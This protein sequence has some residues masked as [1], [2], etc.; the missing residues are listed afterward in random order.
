MSRFFTCLT[1]G[2]L[3]LS[4]CYASHD[5][6]GGTCGRVTCTDSE[7]C[8]QVDC[9]GA[10]ACQ[11]ADLPC[12]DLFC[13]DTCTS[14]ADCT[15]AEVCITPEGAC[16]GSG[17]CVL[18]DDECSRDCPVVC[19]CDG[20]D[21]CNECIANRA[22]VSI[23][24]RGS[25][26]GELCGG[27][28]C[29]AGQQCCDDCAGGQRCVSAGLMCPV[30]PGGCESNFDCPPTEYCRFADGVCGPGPSG[31]TCEVRPTICDDFCTGVCGCDGTP[32]CNACF[33]ANLGVNVGP[34][35]EC[36][37]LPCGR[38]GLPCGPGEY[39]NL[40]PMC[41]GSDAQRCDPLPEACPDI[42]DPVCG[43]DGRTYDNGCIANAAR[44]TVASRG[45][46][47][48]PVAVTCAELL[49]MNPGLVSGTYELVDPSGV[50]QQ[51]YCDMFTDGGGWTLV[52]SSRGQT[53][54]DRASGHHPDLAQYEPSGPNTGVWDGLRGIAPTTDVRFTCRPSFAMGNAVDLSFYDV[55]WYDEW[56]TGTDAQSCFSED[57]GSGRDLPEP[58]RRNNLTGETLMV[59]TP[60][61]AGYLEGED[62]CG[63]PNDFT[64][65]FRDRGMDSNEM[66][67]TDW[68]E[69][70][71]TPKC[72][73]MSLMDGVWQIWIRE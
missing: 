46:C 17:T 32:Y 22:G 47:A 36:M 31:G 68:G 7:V 44:V 18:P 63:D 6:T 37:E 56:T 13:G 11:T 19:G 61:D 20:S 58:A 57:N 5:G 73:F 39:C 43:C 26:S 16:G 25:C 2:A 55:I 41:G 53:I 14:D 8:C 27:V 48:T 66:D 49:R 3:A 42:L 45:P 4:G 65:D 62:I 33:A 1:L 23:D 51:V 21:Y 52:A 72:G 40:G 35:D 70:D 34:P 29:G 67:G 60:W 28:S 10:E 64:V 38:G 24:R 69:D 71:N 30:C 15:G 59:G 9:F 54:D 12:P 50:P